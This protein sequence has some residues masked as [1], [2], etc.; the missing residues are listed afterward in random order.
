M[1]CKASACTGWLR[2]AGRYGLAVEARTVFVAHGQRV[3]CGDLRHFRQV[4]RT[5][6][7]SAT[8]RR[9]PALQVVVTTRDIPIA[10]PC[11]RPGQISGQPLVCR[12]ACHGQ[13]PI[14]NQLLERRNVAR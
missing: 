3:F 6:R 4:S 2:H 13:S 12:D 10:G 9:S 5:P 11:A 7:V 8:I 1:T 14:R